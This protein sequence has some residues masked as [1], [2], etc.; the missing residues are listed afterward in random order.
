MY[1]D[2]YFF[3]QEMDVN[4]DGQVSLEEFVGACMK[5]EKFSSMLALKVIDV[6]VS[7]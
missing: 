4:S 2:G 3:F 1:T 7:E 6:F 5:Q